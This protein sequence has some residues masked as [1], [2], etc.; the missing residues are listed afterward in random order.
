MIYYWAVDRN[1][2][3]MLFLYAKNVQGDLSAHQLRAL[4]RIIE[5]AYT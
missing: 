5:E 4:R 2:I 1:T 3:V